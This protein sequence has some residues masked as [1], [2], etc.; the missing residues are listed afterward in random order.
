[1]TFFDVVTLLPRSQPGLLKEVMIIE[2]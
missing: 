2:V 1:L